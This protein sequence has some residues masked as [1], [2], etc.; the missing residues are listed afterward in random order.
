MALSDTKANQILNEQFDGVTYY[1]ALHTSDPG[2]LGDPATEV[3]TS[4][5][6]YL[7][8]PI[9]DWTT[10]SVRWIKNNVKLKF[11]GL[12]ATR[13]AYVAVW[14]Q[15]VGGEMICAGPT[16][17]TYVVE[18]YGSVTIDANKIMVRIN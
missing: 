3:E 2:P 12:P 9:S 7:R 14:N 18:E 15:Q 16:D 1:V 17:I 6:A 4:G 10:A 11:T 13:I 8:Q 5:S